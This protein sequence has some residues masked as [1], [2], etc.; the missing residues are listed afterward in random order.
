MKLLAIGSL[1]SEHRERWC[2]HN[3]IR[4]SRTL[5][6]RESPVLSKGCLVICLY[7][8]YGI[9]RCTVSAICDRI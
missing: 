1:H 4:V 8:R 5:E 6:Q 3:H 7:M 9:I 2:R